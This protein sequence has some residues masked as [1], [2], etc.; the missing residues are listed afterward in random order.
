MTK[1]TLT[2]LGAGT[3]FQNAITP[4]NANSATIV[5]A[6]D[7]TVSRD[8]TSPNTMGADFD[9]NSHR[10]LNLPS[11]VYLTDPVRLEDLQS[12]NGSFVTAAAGTS[13]HTVPYLDGNNT[14]SGTNAFTN[15]T[16]SASFT[17]GGISIDTTSGTINKGFSINQTSA[18][19]NS[20]TGYSGYNTISINDYSNGQSENDFTSKGL[21][22]YLT[23]GGNTALGSK[24]AGWFFTN[25]TG[26]SSSS[27]VNR[28]YIGVAGIATSSAVMP[29]NGN[30]PSLFASSFQANLYSGAT[31]WASVVGSEV[32]VGSRVTGVPYIIGWNIVNN[33]TQQ[34]S[35][36][37]TGYHLSANTTGK[38]DYGWAMSSLNGATPLATT[39]TVF[40]SLSA[41]TVA[42]VFNFSN[43]TITGNAF[44]FPNTTLTG[45]GSL[46]TNGIS[47]FNN[48]TDSS[49]TSTGSL[50]TSGGLGVAKSAYI[51]T[52]LTI[53]TSASTTPITVLGSASNTVLNTYYNGPCLFYRTTNSTN[54]NTLAVDFRGANTNSYAAVIAQI[55]DQTVGA[56]SGKL[57]FATANSAGA[58]S[59]NFFIYPSSGVSIGL[60]QDV[61]AGAGNLRV[62]NGI[63]AINGTVTAPTLNISG[64]A[65]L[66][67]SVSGSSSAAFGPNWSILNN[68]NDSNCPLWQFNKSRAGGPVQVND[69]MFWIQVGGSDSGSVIREAA[70]MRA[71]VDAVASGS[72]SGRWLWLTSNAGTIA[73]R[74]R[75]TS[76]GGL[77]LGTFASDPGAGNFKA[78]GSILSTGTAGIGYATGA[79][80]TVTQATSRTTGVTLNKTSGAITL[81]SAAGSA[82][83]QTFTVTNST[84][85]ATDTIILNQK[86]GTDLYILL[87]TNV[88]AGSFKISFATTGGTTTEQPVINFNVIKGVSA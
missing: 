35:T 43:L 15:A 5:T 3:A 76:T 11:P 73:E 9:M 10:I 78:T 7:N 83:Y 55:T 87:V 57:V 75:L 65:T 81:V 53:G 42:N 20:F 80:G 77:N 74:L 17:G 24:A 88:A 64:T 26:D 40:A 85:A 12:V 14:W 86:S 27:H 38:W 32:D 48:T 70:D 67:G 13:G 61:D 23:T 68:A 60:G 39:G 82:S 46:S 47:N 84:V 1:I 30:S 25:A 52:S 21:A 66:N 22:V 59:S 8:G 18:G 45:A 28:D 4:I 19:S 2:N 31:G 6:F 51:G 71:E 63:T 44:S 69:F 49:S 79:G 33:G 37:A 62:L 34:A 56:V 41:Q 16:Q 58:A 50:I 29:V 72:V 36:W 54:N